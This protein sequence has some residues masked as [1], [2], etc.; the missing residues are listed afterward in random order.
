MVKVEFRKGL[1]ELQAE[2]GLDKNKNPIEVRFQYAAYDQGDGFP[3]KVKFRLFD[4]MEAYAMGIY[5]FGSIADFIEIKK[6]DGDQSLG[7]AKY[8]PRLKLVQLTNSVGTAK[9]DLS[10]DIK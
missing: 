9:P 10:K 4:G 3:A 2:Q 8:L 5:E 1:S 7:M 6:F